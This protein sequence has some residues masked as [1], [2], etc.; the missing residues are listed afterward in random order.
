M[1][2]H[3]EIHLPPNTRLARNAR[4]RLEQPGR[5]GDPL[6]VVKARPSADGTTIH[7]ELDLAGDLAITLGTDITVGLNAPAREERRAPATGGPVERGTAL[8]S[9][10]NRAAH[11]ASIPDPDFARDPLLAPRPPLPPG[12]VPLDRS[13]AR[14][15]EALEQ[16]AAT[17]DAAAC[18]DDPD[19]QHHVGCGCD[20]APEP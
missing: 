20:D 9:E 4:V 19:G 1:R 14:S 2:A 18:P 15:L 13:T 17:I 7:V 5:P 12:A 8:V 10:Q 3:T 16:A 6:R 11:F